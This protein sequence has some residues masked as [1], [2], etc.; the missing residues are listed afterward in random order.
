MGNVLEQTKGKFKIE[1]KVVGITNENSYR[2]GFT[3]SDK[4][5]KSLQF[6]VQASPTNRVKVEMFGMERDEVVFYNSKERK[7]TRVAWDKR[8]TEISGSKILGSNLYLEGEGEKKT[9][10]VL[11][12]FDA[13]DY[14]LEH[15]KDGDSVRI[16][17]SIDFGQYED[18]EGKVKNTVKFPI[19]SIAKIADIDFEA[20]G[21]K[22]VAS[23]EQEIVVNDTMVDT[24]TKKL[25]ISAYA[26]NYNKEGNEAVGADFIVNGETYPKLANNM[27]KRLGFG[28]F[29]KVYGLIKNETIQ[30]EVEAEDVE[31]D[32]EDDWGGDEEIAS[33]FENN[34]INEYINELQVISVDSGSYE[35]AKY[36]EDDFSS[37]D[38]DAFNGDDEDFGDEEDIDDEDLPF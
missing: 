27:S 33:T 22:E 23:F 2:E 17:G 34:Y 8:N 37:E 9:R 3:K 24:E 20:E 5:Y 21:F 18:A 26:I 1:G 32:E 6:F 38:E 29:I 30:V 36:T 12:E 16:G 31:V 7:S 14:I 13:I 15:I 25:L 35:K 11:V 10:V 19:G 4:P 28:D